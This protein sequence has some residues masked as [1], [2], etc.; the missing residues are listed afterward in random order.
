MA[1][2]R[3]DDAAAAATST[4]ADAGEG[5]GLATPSAH[6]GGLTGGGA[7]DAGAQP[8]PD[9]G[10]DG[11]VGDAAAT[12]DAAGTSP[13]GGTSEPREGERYLDDTTSTA[14]QQQS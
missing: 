10:V 11:T 9:Q 1:E 14:R 3:M 13:D 6:P 5:T 7:G 12:G 4:Q 8:V 2:Q